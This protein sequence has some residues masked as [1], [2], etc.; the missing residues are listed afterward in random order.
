MKKIAV[1][2]GL[3]FPY[4]CK[5]H[6]KAYNDSP[7]IENRIGGL[8]GGNRTKIVA[9]DTNYFKFIG[10]SVEIPSFKIKIKLNAQAEQKL[11]TDKE[12]IIAKAIFHG[13]P[14]IVTPE[15]ENLDRQWKAE[16]KLK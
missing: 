10:D 1:I 6:D 12:S 16:R 14:K 9:T 15:E 5:L 13:I 4:S 8:K 3:L 2:L 11:K 7:I